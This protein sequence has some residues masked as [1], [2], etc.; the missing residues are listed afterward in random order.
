MRQ[1][2]S[3]QPAAK[4][5]PAQAFSC[6]LQACTSLPPASLG[7]IFL[8]SQVFRAPSKCSCLRGKNSRTTSTS[9]RTT[10][11]TS[12]TSRT[13]WGVRWLHFVEGVFVF[14]LPAGYDN[15]AGVVFKR[16]KDCMT[17]L[18]QQ[19]SRINQY[20]VVDNV[21]RAGCWTF[22]YARLA[23]DD[24]LIL[25]PDMLQTVEYL[26]QKLSRNAAMR[27]R[28]PFTCTKSSCCR[29]K[30]SCAPRTTAQHSSRNTWK[31]VHR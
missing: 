13:R 5:Q 10:E 6:L 4:E 22:C 28:P 3:W 21:G 19:H 20:H 12:T 26:Q 25:K 2:V 16:S 24:L 23:A 30:S 17:R 7:P 27:R 8:L 1:A 29:G 18:I 9:I 11:L 15:S 31:A 14:V